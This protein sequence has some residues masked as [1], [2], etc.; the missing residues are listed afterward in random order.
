MFSAGSGTLAPS[1]ALICAAA[2]LSIRPGCRSGFLQSAGSLL[3]S[4]PSAQKKFFK[5]LERR[6]ADLYKSH[7]NPLN[8]LGN[9]LAF[10]GNWVCFLAVDG[11]PIATCFVICLIH[12]SACVLI[13]AENKFHPTHSWPRFLRTDPQ[14]RV[15]RNTIFGLHDKVDTFQ[16]PPRPHPA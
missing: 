9:N 5:P 13:Q 12:C 7:H 1:A 3:I 15:H 16:C 14:I 11:K 4:E 2:V 10:V 6:A 8:D